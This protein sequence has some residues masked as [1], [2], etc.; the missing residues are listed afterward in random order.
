VPSF[1]GFIG[2]WGISGFFCSKP[3]GSRI[4]GMIHPRINLHRFVRL[5]GRLSSRVRLTVYQGILTNAKPA[6]KIPQRRSSSCGKSLRPREWCSC[7]AKQCVGGQCF[8]R[9]EMLQSDQPYPGY[10]QGWGVVEGDPPDW[11][12]AGI[13]ETRQEARV[14]AAEAGPGYGVRWSRRPPRFV[15]SPAAFANSDRRDG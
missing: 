15:P 3:D 6:R 13:F 8:G 9:T 5:P 12:F 2:A 7:F 1:L 11:K 10:V 4:P 14:A